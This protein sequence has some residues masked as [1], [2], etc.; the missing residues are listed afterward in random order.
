MSDTTLD[1]VEILDSCT[2]LT[3][4]TTIDEAHQR[5]IQLRRWVDE[6]LPRVR[7]HLREEPGEG[8]PAVN[9]IVDWAHRTLAQDPGATLPSAAFQVD[10]LT[11]CCRVLANY[12]VKVIERRVCC[13]WCTAHSQDARLIQAFEAGSGA[14][15]ALFACAACRERHQLVPFTLCPEPKPPARDDA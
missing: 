15:G 13:H 1:A 7:E 3:E 4:I 12:V 6:L 10:N 14:G 9:R 5:D 2:R 8:Q 11:I